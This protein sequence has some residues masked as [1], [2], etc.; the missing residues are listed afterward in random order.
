MN[1]MSIRAV[2]AIIT[3]ACLPLVPVASAGDPPAVAAAKP[4]GVP[5]RANIIEGVWNAKVNITVCATGTLITSFDA[6]SMFAANGVFQDTNSNNPILRSAAFGLW[7]QVG[8]REYEFAFRNF[9]FDTVGT[10]LGSQ[11]VRH[12]VELS[13][14]GN[15]YSSEGTSEFYD[16]DGNLF[17][18]GCSDAEATRFE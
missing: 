14:D 1:S 15:S 11:V 3:V 9:R 7:N 5:F 18:T 6:M 10:N 17:M 8:P 13:A 4:A 16:V 2:F 12:K